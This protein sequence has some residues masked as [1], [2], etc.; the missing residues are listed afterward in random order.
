MDT[1]L[2]FF[3]IAMRLKRCFPVSEAGFLAL[4][5]PFCNGA[6]GDRLARYLAADD[7]DRF[8][9]EALEHFIPGRL[10]SSLKQKLFLRAQERGEPLSTYILSLIHI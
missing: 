8:H 10:F 1:L 6:L 7:F 5:M 2:E 9:R 3:K 4:L